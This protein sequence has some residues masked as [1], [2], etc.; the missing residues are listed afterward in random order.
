[1]RAEVNYIR[2]PRLSAFDP[3]LE[4]VTKGETHSTMQT[5]PGERVAI[6][7]ARGLDTTLDRAGFLLVRHVGQVADFKAIEEDPDLHAKFWTALSWTIPVMIGGPGYGVRDE[8]A[9]LLPR[10]VESR[11]HVT[12]MKDGRLRGRFAARSRIHSSKFEPRAR[13]WL[14]VSP[15]RALNSRVK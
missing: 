8:A 5:L 1:M 6:H 4:F 11:G 12:G 7:S 3:K 9:R 13:N 10:L 15:V 2:N 14:G